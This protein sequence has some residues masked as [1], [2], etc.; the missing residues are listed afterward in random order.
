MP[1]INMIAP[2][3]MNKLKMEKRVRYLVLVLLAEFTLAVGIGMGFSYKLWGTTN[4]ISNY[5]TQLTKLK[6]VVAEIESYRTLTN[7]LAPKLDL[8][9]EARERTMSWY[10]MLDKMMG[11]MPTSCR[12]TRISIVNTNNSAKDS[13]SKT[14]QMTIFGNSQSQAKVGE[15]ILRLQRVPELKNLELHYAM[16][17]NGG[18]QP[19][20]DFE[21]GAEFNSRNK[22]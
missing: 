14:Q 5:D 13:A 15:T 6:P 2:R 4:Q 9:N 21:I 3:R 20:V 16:T 1:T 18:T 7:K 11:T 12:L 17:P 8:L 22:L 19:G 10:G